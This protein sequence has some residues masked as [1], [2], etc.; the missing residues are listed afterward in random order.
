MA[1]LQTI[2]RRI[3]S[4]K[5]TRQI[6]KAMQMVAASKLRR[7]QVAAQQPQAYTAAARALLQQFST[8]TA[9]ATHPL[10]VSR[11]VKRALTIFVAGDRGLAGGYNA[12]VIRALA[13][14]IHEVGGEHSAIAIGRRAAAHVAR[15]KNINQ[16]AAYDVEAGDA[17]ADIALPVLAEAIRLFTD[18][19]VDVVHVITTEFVSTVTQRVAVRQLLPVVL[20]AD[21]QPLPEASTEPEPEELVEFAVR[22]VLEAEVTQA[23]LEARA[24]E[25]AARMMAMM[26]ATENADDIIADL[27]LVYNNERQS[28]ITQQISEISAGAEAITAS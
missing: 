19:E 2:N 14:H 6:T 7:A 12:N 3:R 5:N 27:T 22:R 1:S 18:G 16:L 26:N 17:A 15:A 10:F 20:P 23:I 9:A 11:P 21:L 13:R 28:G 8:Q 24:S 4:V 25:Q